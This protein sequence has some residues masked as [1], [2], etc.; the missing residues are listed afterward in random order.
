MTEAART[1]VNLLSSAQRAVACFPFTG[2]ERFQWQYTPGLRGGLRLKDMTREQRAAALA[3]FDAG[4]SLRG[5]QKARDIIALET[6][7]RETERL[8]AE[9]SGADRDPELYY[10]SI[11]GDPTGR[12]H[13][14]WRAN[15]HHLALHFTL[16][17]DDVISPTPLFFGANPAEVRHGHASGLRTLAEEEDLA[18]ALLDSLEPAQKTVAIVEGTT[19]GDILTRN[20][21][22]VDPAAI[23]GGI[24]FSALSG[25]Q[26]ASLVALVR[27]Y[28]GRLA[29]ELN[30]NAWR[31]IEAA[32][33]QALTFAWAGGE[34]RGQ[35]HYYVVKGPTFLLEYDN[36]QNNAN[37][38]HTVWRDFT[39]DWGLDILAHHYATDH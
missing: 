27:H 18:R 26:R 25:D 24:S 16:V 13:W 32:G 28:A 19:F 9:I 29:D 7:L 8:T 11:F 37:H 36:S 20:H 3:L 33:L 4:L 1:F 15:G 6:I 12:T 38:I 22:T 39:N 23:P 34:T 17:D 21:R 35:A 31:R 14:G 10:F 2:D 30:G 5:A